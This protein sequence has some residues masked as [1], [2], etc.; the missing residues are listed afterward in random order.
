M[1]QL[2]NV[3]AVVVGVVIGGL[4]NMG[5]IMVG[6]SIIPAPPG[7]DV[8]DAESMVRSMDLFEARHFVFPFLAHALGTFFGALT[9]GYLIRQRRT[10]V[11][12]IIAAFFLAGGIATTF[13]I[14]A[15]GWFIAADLLLAYI[16]MAMLALWA[17][18]RLAQRR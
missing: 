2:R 8:S 16:P 15:P 5:L 10:I 17:L 4:V 14:P 1:A 11:V 7:V 13:M 6:S 18:N 12:F 9:G 3:L